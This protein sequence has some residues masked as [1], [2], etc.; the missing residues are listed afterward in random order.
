MYMYILQVLALIVIVVGFTL[1]LPFQ[2]FVREK[3]NVILK[4]LKWYEW[5]KNPNFYLVSNI[6]Y[7]CN[8]LKCVT[9]HMCTS[10][11]AL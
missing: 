1:S 3:S 4:K 11:S 9:L 10:I 7:S 6:L 2:I 5:L 8:E